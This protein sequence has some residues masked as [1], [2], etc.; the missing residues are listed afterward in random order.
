MRNKAKDAEKLYKLDSAKRSS[1]ITM[2][3]VVV[4]DY[5]LVLMDE[6]IVVPMP[7]CPT[8]WCRFLKWQGYLI[9]MSL[10]KAVKGKRIYFFTW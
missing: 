2:K 4:G 10:T 3:N 8:W 5:L 7:W 6:G 1:G 9:G